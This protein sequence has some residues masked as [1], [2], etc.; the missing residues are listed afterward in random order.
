MGRGSTHCL[1]FF[2]F[3]F[4][5]Y[6]ASSQV[7]WENANFQY[8]S[9]SQWV[10][11]TDA[12]LSVIPSKVF[13]QPKN[14]VVYNDPDGFYGPIY[15]NISFKAGSKFIYVEWTANPHSNTV[16]ELL[17]E[18]L[19]TVGQ[20][21][22]ANCWP[23]CGEIDVYEM[24]RDEGATSLA[25][26]AA[27]NYGQ[28]TLH[29]GSRDNGCFCPQRGGNEIWFDSSA[30]MTSACS[31]EFQNFPNEPNSLAIIFDQD[32]NGQYLQFIQNP[33][34]VSTQKYTYIVNETGTVTSTKIYNNKNSFYGFDPQQCPQGDPNAATGWPFFNQAMKLILWEQDY[35]SLSTDSLSGEFVVTNIQLFYRYNGPPTGSNT[36]SSSSA[37]TSTT[38]RL[39][40]VVMFVC[41]IICV[42]QVYVL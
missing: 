36:G 2:V 27:S 35:S 3:L 13:S 20:F 11:I 14:V 39:S 26:G 31:A 40:L 41:V 28:M 32:D 30:P 1:F 5:N 7:L 24:L 17:S 22:A 38:S 25:Y 10:W 21:S 12:G 23:N 6:P 37:A 42:M 15:T 34:L 18:E 19:I 4:L 9:A 33:E 16:I 29:T 8:D